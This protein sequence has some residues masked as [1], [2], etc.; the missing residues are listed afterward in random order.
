MIL[1]IFIARMIIIKNFVGKIETMISVEKAKQLILKKVKPL[2]SIQVDLPKSLW[3]VL[4]TSVKSPLPLPPFDQ[5]AMDG[6]ALRSEDVVQKKS[7]VVVGEVAAGKKYKQ[8]LKTGEAVRI[9]T[10]AQVPLGADAVVMQEKVVVK[11]KQLF[12][13]DDYLTSPAMNVRKKG[14][15]IVKNKIAKEKGSLINPA[16]VGYL[17]AMGITAVEV[18]RNPTITIVV[19]GSELKKPGK[20]LLPGEIYESNSFAVQSALQTMGL[21]ARRIVFIQ[22]HSS[23]TLRA[24][25][26]AM[27]TS[28]LVLI[29]GGISVG[30]YD[31]VGSSLQALNVKNIF[32]K[33]KQ[34]PG[35]PLF[36][37]AH[38][39]G[40]VFALP[41]NPAAV[42]S[43]F[44]EYVYPAIRI[45]QGRK[46]VFLQT[47]FLPIARDFTKK[48][49]LSLFLKGLVQGKAVHPLEGQESYILSSFSEANALI[50]LSESMSSLKKGDFV[51]VHLLPSV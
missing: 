3:S 40:F 13:Q 32:Y 8:R 27:Q 49:G 43:C 4:A 23:N 5:S 20:K 47:V 26:Q 28:D 2:E 41:G 33:I 37:G 14:S 46:E 1:V 44:Y 39:K 18:I 11:N 38:E 30:D 51:E 17:A 25:R 19:T 31:Y 45:M 16:C 22:D 36:F 6:Y 48:P 9:F 12:I 7:I 29:T 50:Y 42:L 21:A 24:I 15:Q 10:G 35:K 34:K